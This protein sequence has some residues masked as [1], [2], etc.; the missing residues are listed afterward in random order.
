MV[1]DVDNMKEKEEMEQSAFL[2]YFQKWINE[3]SKT[4]FTA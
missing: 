4:Y 3:W 2:P 1:D